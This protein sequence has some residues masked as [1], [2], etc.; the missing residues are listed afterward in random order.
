MSK[1]YNIYDVYNNQLDSAVQNQNAYD[2]YSED[3][4]QFY[5]DKTSGQFESSQDVQ[6]YEPK[7]EEELTNQVKRSKKDKDLY[8]FIP[9]DWLPNWVKKGYNNSIEGL[10]YNVATG[11]SFFDLGQYEKNP[12]DIGILEDIGS[13]LISFLT[14]TDIATMYGT[15]VVGGLAYKAGLKTTVGNIIKAG[16]RDKVGKSAIKKSIE[17]AV[18]RNSL[19]ATEILTKNGVSKPVAEKVIQTSMKRVN[20]QI[21]ESSFMGGTGLGFYSGLQSALG[22]KVTTGDISL[23]ATLADASKGAILGAVTS[24]SGKALNNKLISSLGKPETATQKLA[25]D[26]A[27]KALET[28]QFGIVAPALEGEMPTAKDFAHAAGTIGGLWVSR[29]VA[30]KAKELAGFDN[31]YV[32][33]KEYSNIYGKEKFELQQRSAVW[34][35]KNGNQI[36]NVEFKKKKD[37]KG[38]ESYYVEGN[39]RDKKGNVSESK[40]TIE[41]DVFVKQ[42]YARRPTRRNLESVKKLETAR[43]REVFGRKKNLKISDKQFSETIQSINPNVDLTK[44]KTGYSQLSNI[45]KIKLLDT[46]RKES[47]TK[48]IFTEFKKEG[49]DEFLLPRRRISEALSFD[50]LRQAK[51][52]VRTQFGKETVKEINAADARGVALTGTYLQQLTDRG[53]FQGGIFNKIFGLNR[54]K[55]GEGVITIRTEKQAKAYAEDLG[56]RLGDPKARQHPDVKKLREILTNIYIDA[57]RAGIPV[58]EFRKDYF[59]NHIK[60]KLLETMGQDI[61][62]MD[63]IDMKLTGQRLS[64]SQDSVARVNEIYKGETDVKLT[65]TTK[66]ALTHL[67]DKYLANAKQTGEVLT[68][69]QA[70]AKSW[71]QLRNDIYGQSYTTVGA[72]EKSRKMELPDSFYERD[73]RIVLAK[74]VTDVAKRIAFVE[75]FGAKGEVMDARLKTLNSLAE[76]L[77]LSQSK[78]KNILFQEKAL[79][80]QT[81]N[82]FTGTI[83]VDPLKNWGNAKAREAL[84]TIVDFQV[85]TKIGLG[86]A[87]IPNVTQTLISTAVKAGYWNTLKGTHKLVFDK[88]FRREVQKSGI[89]TLSVF[90]MVSGL[91]P[92]SSFM[93]KFA[94]FTTRISGFQAMNKANQYISAAA[95]KLYIEGLL[96]TSQGRDLMGMAGLSFNARRNWASKNL[97]ELGIQPGTKKISDQQ[98]LET[99]YRFSRDAQLQRNVLNDPLFFNDPRF[100]PF[101]LFK[102][103]GYK[104]F[105]WVREN[106]AKDFA[107]GNMLPLLRLGAGGALGAQFIVWSKKALN[108]FLA[109]EIVYDENRLFIPGLPEQ[110]IVKEGIVNTD[111]SKYTWS[112]FLDHV[113]TV[114][115]MGFVADI[116]ASESKLRAIEFL[117]KPAIYQDTMK[118]V[119]A[120]TRMYKDLNDFGVGAY[121]RAPKYVAPIFGTVARRFARRFETPGQRETY[122]R[123]RKGIIKGR[124]LDSLINEQPKEA[125]KL[126]NAWNESNKDNPLTDSDINVNA[127]YDRLRKKY[128]K[129]LKEKGVKL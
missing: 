91:E 76:S 125:G 77:P 126:L 70:L 35:D 3:A 10:T 7:A 53:L 33:A 12:E 46:M 25:Y 41:G 5:S 83:E 69:E 17:Q 73:A 84:K 21:V 68:P 97:Q 95:G 116:F 29:G 74:Y 75:K 111:M 1:Q 45:E 65:S 55:T 48:K 67:R 31:P 4:L 44:S 49:T 28:A 123:Y 101:I 115:A 81:F 42:Q 34:V 92:S 39:I 51:N 26:V 110:T 127:I 103:F 27:G 80:E 63:T 71:T 18:G 109:D 32:T 23:T 118:A 64:K 59:P 9:E 60:Q 108:M 37:N 96:K 6:K 82:S 86:Y 19:K 117:V 50:L 72:L 61:F 62:K 87:T 78:A 113:A 16:V 98:M 85:G 2:P 121:A 47:L 79:L 66:E 36:T 56:R 106:V 112:D 52:R 124:I 15:G 58:K 22:Q 11:K 104:Q 24:G 14:P 43:R 54:I 120:F 114:G 38:V 13:T 119:D 40:V 30:R 8:G 90:Q 105:N 20:N 89:S 100:R 93:G 128:E 129:R 102:R 94:D 122:Q 107:R 88:N 57:K 99:M